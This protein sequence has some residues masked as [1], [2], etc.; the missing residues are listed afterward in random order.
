[1]TNTDYL[2][3]DAVVKSTQNG[4]FYLCKKAKKIVSETEVCI[5][6][7]E[8]IVLFNE[9]PNPCNNYKCLPIVVGYCRQN[10]SSF[11]SIIHIAMIFVMYEHWFDTGQSKIEKS[12]LT[13]ISNS[14][15]Y[16]DNFKRQFNWSNLIIKKQMN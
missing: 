1:M 14:L 6:S 12:K 15:S 5:I 4:E 9:L 3:K 7:P 10:Y 11:S 2:T 13:K 16:N 8:L